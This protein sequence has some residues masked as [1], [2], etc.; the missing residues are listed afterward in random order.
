[1][2]LNFVKLLRIKITKKSLTLG[3]N[4][5]VAMTSLSSDEDKSLKL[6]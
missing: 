2:K 3:Q 6:T 1:M 5:D 4:F